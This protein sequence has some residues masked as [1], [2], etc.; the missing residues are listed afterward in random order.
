MLQEAWRS[1]GQQLFV[2]EIGNRMEWDKIQV[3]AHAAGGEA[4]GSK[5]LGQQFSLCCPPP[6]TPLPAVRA[7]LQAQELPPEK[8]P[9][10]L[11][12]RNSYE[13]DAGHFVGAERPLEVGEV[14]KLLCLGI[15]CATAAS[16]TRATLWV[17]S[18]RWR[19][20]LTAHACII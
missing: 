11:D 7:V 20:V 17:R 8:R 5:H 9:V 16:G 15:T 19:W 13:W 12:L 6:L 14:H 10:V 3:G 2:P 1:Q 4:P 18:G